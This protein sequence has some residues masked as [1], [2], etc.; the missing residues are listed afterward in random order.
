MF[1]HIKFIS[2]SGEVVG[3][4]ECST[5]DLEPGQTERINCLSDGQSPA[6]TTR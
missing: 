4:D 5:G 1:I 6:S 2:K 3:N